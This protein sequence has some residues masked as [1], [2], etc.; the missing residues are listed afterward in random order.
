MR[1]AIARYNGVMY[2][3]IDYDAMSLHAKHI[4]DR[5]FLICSGMY[6]LVRPQDEIANYKLPIETKGLS[7]FWKE[8]I[9]QTLNESEFDIIVDVL[10]GSYKKMI[11]WKKLHK[12]VVV[13][14][15]FEEKDGKKKKMTHGVKTVKGAWIKNLCEARF[16]EVENIILEKISKGETMLEVLQ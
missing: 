14:D 10:P 2:S 7:H 13:V 9:T 8:K 12:K 4:F 6:G 5:H 15:F 1:A 3:A 16:T 11:D